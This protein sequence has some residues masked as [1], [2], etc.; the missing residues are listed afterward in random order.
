MSV[1]CI[2]SIVD[3]ALN[4]LKGEDSAERLPDHVVFPVAAKSEL[5]NDCVLSQLVISEEALQ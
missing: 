2:V 4:S 1:Q 3:G 5:Q